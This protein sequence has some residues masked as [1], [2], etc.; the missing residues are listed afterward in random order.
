MA[1]R[2]QVSNPV[3]ARKTPAQQR[4]LATVA[5]ILEAAARILETQGLGAYS[6]NA[7]AARA[8]V[9]I[10]SLYQY[11]PNKDSITRA[12]IRRNVDALLADLRQVDCAARADTPMHALSQV[13]DVA[14][15]HQL[16]RPELA[17]LLDL[18]EMRL[19]AD[20]DLQ[21]A[22]QEARGIFAQCLRV[23][24][25]VPARELAVVCDDLFAI[26]KGMV[27]AAGQR[28]EASEKALS[29]RVRR[30]VFGYVQWAG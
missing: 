21:R 6:T 20:Q 10:G 29:R 14:V 12:L 30:A 22:G 15:R 7:V 18:E 2:K 17:R 1:A 5:A 4:S 11:F 8:G 27:D 24:D 9:S 28:G 19:P 13:V 16:Q 23:T 3:S 25:M 26:V